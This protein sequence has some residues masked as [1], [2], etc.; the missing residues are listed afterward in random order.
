V[1]AVFVTSPFSSKTHTP[2][3]RMISLE[4]VGGPW[5]G[6]T[7]HTDSTDQVEMW[8]ANACY[9]IS[10]HGAIGERCVEVTC[11]LLDFAQRHG[12]LAAE[13]VSPLQAEAYFVAAHR[14]T[15]TEVV[16]TFEYVL[17]A[18]HPKSHHEEPNDDYSESANDA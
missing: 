17:Q 14:E 9:A 13:T 5:D 11:D 18:E 16:V 2:N 7:L 15:E 10:H 12:W 8:L 4:F 3:E 6:Q 1:I